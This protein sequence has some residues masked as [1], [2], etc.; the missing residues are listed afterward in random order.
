MA[1]AKAVINTPGQILLTQA[2]TGYRLFRPAGF[3]IASAVGF[4]PSAD[5]TGVNGPVVF[6]GSKL[7]VQVKQTSVNTARYVLTVPEGAG[8]FDI[9]NIMLF[10]ENDIEEMVPFAFVVLPVPYQKTVSDPN[11]TTTP[12]SP[13]PIPGDRFV[14]NITIK[15][16]L[17]ATIQSIEVITPTFSSLAFYEDI[18]SIPPPNLN[19]WDAF[20]AHDDPRTNT[21]AML[22]KRNDD[23]YWGIPFWQNFRDPRFGVLDG[24]I[25]GDGY[26]ADQSGFLDGQEY[27]MPENKFSGILGGSDYTTPEDEFT[28]EIGGLDYGDN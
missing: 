15:H 28:G 1:E 5:A 4:E 13:F 6:E 25:D 14:C 16:S 24:G 12:D 26:K 11:L 20:V 9:G 17:N 3:K 10:A 2:L 8:P 27:L 21:P 19:P 7:L 22:A 23:T 18:A